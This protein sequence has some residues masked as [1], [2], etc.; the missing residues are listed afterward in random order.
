M[1]SIMDLPN[2]GVIMSTY[3]FLESIEIVT[4]IE[5]QFE[6]AHSTDAGYDILSAIE[7]SIP[8]NSSKLI[9]TNLKVSI[10]KGYVGII[11]SRSGLSVKSGLDVGAGVIDS[12]YIGEVKVLLRNTS[13]KWFDYSIGDKIAQMVIVPICPFRV[14][15][16]DK[17]KKSQRE[18]N[19]FGSTGK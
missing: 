14:T 5:H 16:V 3:E 15:K 11:K 7:G 6:K 10:P 9:S 8:A 19:G 4:D 2:E 13:D 18:A 17:L 1:A 12:G